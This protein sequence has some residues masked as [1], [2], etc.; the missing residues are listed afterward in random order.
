M[1]GLT[2]GW[3]TW[4]SNKIP[5]LFLPFFGRFTVVWSKLGLWL[6]WV[7]SP[8][9]EWHNVATA[10]YLRILLELPQSWGVAPPSSPWGF[11]GEGKG[12]GDWV[13]MGRIQ[14][15]KGSVE[16]YIL[17]PGKLDVFFLPAS[18][19][20]RC[21]DPSE[22]PRVDTIHDLW[23]A[24]QMSREWTKTIIKAWLSFSCLWNAQVNQ[25]K[26][27]G[28]KARKCCK[29]EFGKLAAGKS[30]SHHHN[31][32]NNNNNSILKNT[33]QHNNNNHNKYIHTHTNGPANYISFFDSIEFS[34]LKDMVTHLSSMAV[35][36]AE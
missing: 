4:Y 7:F 27:I 19:G 24:S 29:R 34:F 21:R 15:P 16:S 10:L 13:T 20:M 28:Y 30:N 32:N 1:P 26:L 18:C 23:Y 22:K 12:C 11:K 25:D 5:I 2:V 6:P 3:W 33:K 31:N 14:D 8:N 9:H 36:N 17:N 35:F